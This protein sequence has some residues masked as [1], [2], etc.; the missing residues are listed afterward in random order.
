LNA[1]LGLSLS[2]ATPQRRWS[3]SCRRCDERH[4]LSLF[5]RQ[6]DAAL[7]AIEVFE[8]FGGPGGIRTHDLFHAMGDRSITYGALNWTG[9]SRL[10]HCSR[11]G[12][13]AVQP[14]RGT[15]LHSVKPRGRTASA[16]LGTTQQ[17][18][19]DGSGKERSLHVEARGAAWGSG[20]FREL[21]RLDVGPR[22][23]RNLGP[24]CRGTRPCTGPASS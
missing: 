2:A 7:A 1:A 5:F 22:N 10:R 3:V 23:L 6:G 8:L 16:R 12:W 19:V 18:P 13:Y 24:S 20:H 15:M 17:R 4:V 9:W 14:G 11:R 21:Q